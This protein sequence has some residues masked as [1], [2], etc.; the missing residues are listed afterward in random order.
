[1]EAVIFLQNLVVCV[2]CSDGYS[3]LF[4]Q[5]MLAFHILVLNLDITEPPVRQSAHSLASLTTNWSS[6]SSS[7]RYKND[8][9]WNSRRRQ[10]QCY[11]LIR[12][13]DWKH[14]V[15]LLY[16]CFQMRKNEGST[17]LRPQLGIIF[18]YRVCWYSQTWFI[19]SQL[20]VLTFEHVFLFLS[21]MD[22]AVSCSR[23]Y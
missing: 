17:D 11:H 12:F 9:G 10:R 14:L 20:C 6:Y 18:S 21:W 5:T 19:N 2:T 16:C 7:L 23:F 8:T 1:M 13:F 3:Q 4:C 22:R 15:S